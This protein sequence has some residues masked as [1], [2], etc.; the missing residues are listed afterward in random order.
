MTYAGTDRGAS[1]GKS[2][3]ETAQALIKLDEHVTKKYE[4]KKTMPDELKMSAE[5]ALNLK[6]RLTSIFD[7]HSTNALSYAGND[8]GAFY[9]KSVAETAQALIKLDEHVIKMRMAVK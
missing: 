5:E 2:V 6:E 1:Y 7:K 9:G 8:R 4:R 3:A